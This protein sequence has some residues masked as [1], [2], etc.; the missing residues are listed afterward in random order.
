MATVNEKMTAIADAI[1]NKTGGVDPLTLDDMA[2]NIPN[3]YDAGRQAEYDKFW[4]A[5][6]TKGN[7]K[8]YTYAFSGGCWTD[9]T[10]RPKYDI[11]IEGT[12]ATIGIF[13]YTGIVDL[14]G[15]LER[16]GVKLDFSQYT[17][18]LG[19]P[20]TWANIEILPDLDCSNATAV[21][22]YYA[23]KLREVG[24]IKVRDDGQ[25]S[26]NFEGA[27]QI[28]IITIDGPLGKSFNV[29][30]CKKLTH[31]SLMSF[32]NA[33]MD[34]SGSGTTYTMT[35][36]TTNLAKLTDGEKAIATQ[37]GWTLA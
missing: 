37:K 17:G 5:F 36:G 13:N 8:L 23:Y 28:E 14:K 22:F 4:D 21:S 19:N 9:D 1:R 27:T 26:W 3:V 15:C 2:E 30:Y 16:Q 32:V 20:F 10:F 12:N 35:M 24:T 31:D 6:Q 29:S 11:T 34:Y 18:G 25:V 7:K 33:L